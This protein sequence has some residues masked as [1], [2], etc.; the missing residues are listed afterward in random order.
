MERK[1]EG[2]VAVV[3]EAGLV[4]LVLV[5]RLT[6]CWRRGPSRCRVGERGRVGKLYGK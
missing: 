3:V 2:E 1:W 4:M 5:G 6:R